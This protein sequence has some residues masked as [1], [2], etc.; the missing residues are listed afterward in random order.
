MFLSELKVLQTTITH[1]CMSTKLIALCD[2]K[3]LLRK[4]V[5]CHVKLN[6][7]TFLVIFLQ[8]HQPLSYNMGTQT[9]DN[10]LLKQF[11]LPLYMV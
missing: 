10:F 9:T 7:V 1:N 2:T 3:G 8:L 6:F 11:T 5:N 4:I